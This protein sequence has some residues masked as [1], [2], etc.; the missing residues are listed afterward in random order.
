MQYRREGMEKGVIRVTGP[1]GETVI[2]LKASEG[3]KIVEL[4]VTEGVLSEIELIREQGEKVFIALSAVKEGDREKQEEDTDEETEI[5][6][7]AIMREI[8]E[9]AKKYASSDDLPKF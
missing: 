4:P 3:Q 1:E 5:D 9:E 2:E 7:D 8:K 6:I